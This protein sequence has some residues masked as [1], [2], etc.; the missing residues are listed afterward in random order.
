MIKHFTVHGLNKKLDYDLEF[1]PDLN[2][3]TG[4]NGSGK[5]TLLKLLWYMV[6]PNVERTVPEIPFVS[7]DLQTDAFRLEIERKPF[8][9]REKVTLTFTRNGQKPHTAELWDEEFREPFGLEKVETFN[10]L[11]LDVPTGSVFF[12]TFRRIEG[13][14]SLEPDRR[15]RG[16]EHRAGMP[17]GE[18]MAGYS[19]MMTVKQHRFVASI[20][21]ADVED[22]LTRQYAEVSE[23][24]NKLHTELSEF[25]STEISTGRRQGKGGS[26]K[27]INARM[28]PEQILASIQSKVEDIEDRRKKLL[29][30][31]SVL[32]ELIKE[33]FKDKGIRVTANLTFGEAKEAIRASILSAGEKQMLSFICYNA[34][35]TGIPI[36]IDEPELSLHIDWQRVLFPTLLSQDTGN[37][38]IVSTHSPFIYSK[39]PEKELILALDKGGE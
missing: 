2:I 16:F 1:N 11:I 21:T 4:K 18:A 32:A 38:F 25:I 26:G 31:F 35:N 15:L 27:S 17:I 34:F 22:L 24:T 29:K 20:S 28:T 6:S 13:G 12:P 9:N 23:Q 39:Y 19:Q 5:T 37:Q 7:A 30:P 10:R 14:F 3:V 8:K 36:F 33:I